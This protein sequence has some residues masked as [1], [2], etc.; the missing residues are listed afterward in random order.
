MINVNGREIETD[1]EGYLASLDDWSEDVAQCL[2]EYFQ[3]SGLGLQ[4]LFLI[5][6]PRERR[7][8]DCRQKVN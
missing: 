3:Q 8:Q 6:R 7:R 4:S 5:R 1:A 2:A